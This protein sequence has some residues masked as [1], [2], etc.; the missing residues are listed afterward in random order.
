MNGLEHAWSSVL[1]AR[2]MAGEILAWKYASVSFRVGHDCKYTPDFIVVLA[3]GR[4]ELQECKGFMRDDALVKLRACRELYPWLPLRLI[5][6][7]KGGA[8]IEELLP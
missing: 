4:L 3:D 2:Q 7:A 1:F 8:W 5:R 6:A